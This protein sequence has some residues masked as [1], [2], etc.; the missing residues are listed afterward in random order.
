MYMYMYTDD[1][2]NSIH[3]KGFNVNNN[4]EKYRYKYTYEHKYIYM[5]EHKYTHEKAHHIKDRWASG[6]VYS[7]NILQ[8]KSFKV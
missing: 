4:S 2:E 7:K 3:D 5:Y 1:V 8:T 6:K